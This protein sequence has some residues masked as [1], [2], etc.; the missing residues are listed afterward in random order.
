MHYTK[1]IGVFSLSSS[2][3]NSG[4]LG[5][6]FE[7][8]CTPYQATAVPSQHQGLARLDSLFMCCTGAFSARLPRTTMA[9]SV[10]RPHS[11]SQPWWTTLSPSTSSSSSCALVAIAYRTLRLGLGT[12][13][14]PAAA[15]FFHASLLGL[16]RKCA[17]SRFPALTHSLYFPSHNKKRN[18]R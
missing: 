10:I 18:L 17:G 1:I 4:K 8:L 6:H 16:L 13:R 9:T 7:T 14:R 3:T 12:W 11:T 5:L 2:C 15:W